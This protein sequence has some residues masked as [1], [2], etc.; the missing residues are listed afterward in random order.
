MKLSP[1][2]SDRLVLYDNFGSPCA[3]RVRITLLEKGL[4]WD[5]QVIDLS[6]LE[7]RRPDYLRINQR[8]RASTGPRCTCGV[9]VQ[10]HHRVPG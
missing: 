5:T 1:E 4:A 6:R 7:Q 3:R 9:R 2:N 8:L 10:C